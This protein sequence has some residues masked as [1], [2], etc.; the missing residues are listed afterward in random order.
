MQRYHCCEWQGRLAAVDSESGLLRQYSLRRQGA[1]GD[2]EWKLDQETEDRF[3]PA[4]GDHVQAC[5][6][7][8]DA[9]C[10]TKRLF[11]SSLPR[12]SN[13]QAA[14]CKLLV[15][16][17]S[18]RRVVEYGRCQ[19]QNQT[20]PEDVKTVSIL[21]GPVVVWTEGKRLQIMYAPADHSHNK[22]MMLRT[23]NLEDLISDG[24]Q[25]RSVDNVWPFLWPKERDMYDVGC[26]S[27]IVAFLKLKVTAAIDNQC[28]DEWVC[29]QLKLHPQRLI[30]KLL[31]EAEFVPRDYGCIAS[32]L[33]IHKSYSV[34]LSTGDIAPTCKFLV[35]TK[36]HQVVLLQGGVVMR[37]VAL[38]YVPN[39]ISPLDVRIP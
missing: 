32:C 38:N 28:M 21:D 26:S 10:G 9:K 17:R 24:Y 37:C 8:M 27:V 31:Q 36:Y 25:L 14:S 11:I 6:V 4:G 7:V 5:E 3:E 30:V 29:L 18:E 22:K 20:T 1:D 15:Y 13:G 2:A 19:P 23:Y 33:A 34:C 16:S 35:G 39:Q 12:R